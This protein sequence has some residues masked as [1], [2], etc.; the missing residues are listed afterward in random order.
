MIFEAEDDANAKLKEI[1]DALNGC[2]STVDYLY[3]I[4]CILQEIAMKL[5]VKE[6]FFVDLLHIS[7]ENS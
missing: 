6:E 3:A 5:D 7:K 4:V 2:N 1:A